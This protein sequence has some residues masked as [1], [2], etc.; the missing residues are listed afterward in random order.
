MLLLYG[1]L[2]ATVLTI[3]AALTLRRRGQAAAPGADPRAGGERPAGPAPDR[4]RPDAVPPVLGRAGRVRAYD[5]PAPAPDGGSRDAREEFGRVRERR[6]REPVVTEVA[7]LAGRAGGG[8]AGRAASE[9]PDRPTIERPARLPEERPPRPAEDP[10]PRPAGE[11]SSRPAE[12]RN[13]P[14]KPEEDAFERFLRSGKD[15]LDFR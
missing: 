8:A 7:P 12:E 14:A 1:L 13:R 2:L 10:P 5:A 11:R 15:D 4:R 6:R 9:P 3:W